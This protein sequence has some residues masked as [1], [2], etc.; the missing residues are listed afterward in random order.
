MPEIHIRGYASFL[1]F[2]FVI[3]RCVLTEQEGGFFCSSGP[4]A[5]TLQLHSLCLLQLQGSPWRSCWLR[6]A[7]RLPHPKSIFSFP[8][9]SH[10]P[11]AA[12]ATPIL[13]ALRPVSHLH[14]MLSLFPREHLCLGEG[15]SS[16]VCWCFHGYSAQRPSHQ[17][18]HHYYIRAE[19]R[20]ATF[21]PVG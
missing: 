4:P 17:K 2:G 14:V 21:L 16:V 12:P 9:V 18:L 13:C 11:Q 6:C 19:D 7:A 8:D 10:S 20:F 5:G 1:P 15:V 3:E